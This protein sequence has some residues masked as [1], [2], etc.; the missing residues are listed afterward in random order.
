MQGV[1][2]LFHTQQLAAR[3][4]WRAM[5]MNG[6]NRGNPIICTECDYA[7]YCDQFQ[8]TLAAISH[9]RYITTVNRKQY[10]A[11]RRVREFMAAQPDECQAQY[12]VEEN[13]EAAATRTK[14]GQAYV[15]G[16]QKW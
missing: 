1:A 10:I 3:R 11:V 9:I 5:M 4:E 8:E 7:R 15:V 12:L 14:T 16:H 13:A 2:I 6:I